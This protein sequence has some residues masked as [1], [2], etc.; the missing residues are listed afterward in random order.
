MG[1]IQKLEAQAHRMPRGDQ[2]TSRASKAT[3]DGD[4]EAADSMEDSDQ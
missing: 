4:V 3:T 1:P 2:D